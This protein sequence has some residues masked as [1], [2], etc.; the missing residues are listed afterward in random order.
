MKTLEISLQELSTLLQQ[1]AELGAMKALEEAGCLKPYL[2]K[3][4]A[5]KKYGRA[6]VERWLKEQLITPRKDG[7]DSA[8]W[9]LDRLELDAVAKAS[10]RHTYLTVAER[11]Y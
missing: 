11:K 5:F 1:A 9:R 8:A 4:E 6:N 2:N 10:N 7:N 3:S